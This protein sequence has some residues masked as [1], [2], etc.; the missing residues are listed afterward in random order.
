MPQQKMQ[1]ILIKE[2]G[3]AGQLMRGPFPK[4]QPQ[5]ADLLVKVKATALNRADIMQRQ[6]KYPPPNGASPILGL[7]MAGVVEQ[8]GPQCRGGNPGDRVCGLLPG[9]GYAEYAVI[10]GDMALPIPAHLSFEEAAA[11]PEVFLTAYQTLFWLGELQEGERVLIHAGAS[12]VGTAAIQLA[13]D[14]GAIPIVTA[15]AER[16]LSVCRD[17][18]AQAAI[19]YKD[20]PFAPKVLEA[21]QHQGVHLILDFVGAAY[22]QQNLSV[23][24]TDG[25]LVLIALLGGAKVEMVDL[26]VFLKKRIKLLATTLRARSQEYKTQLTRDFAAYALPRLQD[27]R[28]K[29]VIDSVFDWDNVRQAHEYME[30]NQNIG[31]IILTGM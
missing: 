27:G 14:A 23:L 31:K 15:G 11:I 17:L 9:G 3:D 6:G 25:R 21:V 13:R 5:A 16:K 12:G 24:T 4:P 26:R 8:A 22:W 30:Q 20:G 10:P 2:P 7:E 19:T 1:A 18:G 29:P 28:L